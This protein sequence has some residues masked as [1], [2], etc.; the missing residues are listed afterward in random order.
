E[1]RPPR[2]DELAE[3]FRFEVPG[4]AALMLQIMEA[5]PRMPKFL[6]RDAASGEI[7]RVD[8]DAVLAHPRF[9]KL[10]ERSITGFEGRRA[11]PLSVKTY[12]GDELTSEALK[13]KPHLVYFWFTNCPPCMKT[14]PLLVELYKTYAPKG[15]AI[16]AVNADRVLENGYT[17]EDR[18]A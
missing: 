17:D 5:D 9:G 15:F 12:A 7:E 3:Q 10:L 11:P 18:A 2:L 4:E 8:V 6:K 14:A 16:V 13:G 1:G